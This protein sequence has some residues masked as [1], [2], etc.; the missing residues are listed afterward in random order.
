M[1]LTRI[2]VHSLKD[3]AKQ[4]TVIDVVSDGKVGLDT[5]IKLKTYRDRVSWFAIFYKYIPDAVNL[6][7][8]KYAFNP[9]EVRWRRTIWLLVVLACVAVLTQQISNRIHHFL[10]TPVSVDVVYAYEDS[11]PFPSVAICNINVFRSSQLT[12]PR[13]REFL[14]RFNLLAADPELNVSEYE[15]VLSS[16]EMTDMYL[17][18]A[19]QLNET[20]LAISWNQNYQ[21][22]SVLTVRMTDWGVCFV[23]NDIDNGQEGLRVSSAGNSRGLEI[24]LDVLQ[25][26]YFFQPNMRVAAGFQVLLYDRGTEPLVS[27]QGFSIASGVQTNVGVDIIEMTN[28]EEPYGQC[29]N[30]T[31]KY[32]DRYCHITCEAECKSEFLIGQCGC[33]TMAMTENFTSEACDC[34]LPCFTREYV[35]SVSF[36]NFPSDFWA[37]VVAG[38]FQETRSSIQKNLC[39]LTVYMKDLSIQRIS[40]Q[41]DYTFACLMS[42]IGGSL[43]L[44]LG[45]SVLTLFELVDLI[46]YSAYVHSRRI[47]T[48][49]P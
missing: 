25:T 1:P 37:D 24:F 14:R 41:A 8:M 5:P 49:N 22:N 29:R 4:Q 45:G 26:E 23:F 48:S 44:W 33:R 11:V 30:K 47:P 15:S 17:T 21:N 31:L 32:S 42:D 7:G 20:V 34:P 9:A 19:H 35:P 36:S 38:L 16:Y 39:A 2:D 18:L 3:F 6:S 10:S 27:G 46:G 40:Q 28:L 43:G 12:D 13:M